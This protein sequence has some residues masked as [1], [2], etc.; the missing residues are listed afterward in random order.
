MKRWSTST[1]SIFADLFGV[2]FI[3]L[4]LASAIYW[5]IQRPVFLLKGVDI[6]V[7]GNKDAITSKEVS[8]VLNGHIRGNFFT[9]DLEEIAEQLKKVPWV[10]DSSVGRVWPNK[11]EATLYL[12]KPVAVWGEEKLL[13]EDGTIFVANQEIAESKGALPRIFGP[14]DRR[15]EIY[16]QYLR[17]EKTCKKLGFEII[18]LDYSEYS[19]WTLKFKR[20]EGK[21]IKLVLKKGENASRMDEQL[22][23]V[24]D[25]L[26]EIT[27]RLG[28]EPSALDARYEKGIAVVKPVP[29]EETDLPEDSA[30]EAGD[31]KN[32]R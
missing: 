28:V 3:L 27:A 26:P 6:E 19:G 31:K 5:F 20:P 7:V 30:Q 11:L 4:L 23:H 9:A 10:R 2:L 17:F 22:E 32:V 8:Q 25:S 24:L 16:D 14:V 12:H 29:E 15:M 18:S 1:F 13:A 21:V